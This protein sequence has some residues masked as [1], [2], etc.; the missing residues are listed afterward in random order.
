MKKFLIEFKEFA[1]KGNVVDLSVGVI[2]GGAFQAIIKSFIDNILNPIIG[3]LFKADLS[4]I[5]LKIGSV[6]LGIGAFVSS[7]INF[8][9][10]ALVLFI[11]VYTMNNIR[12]LMKEDKPEEVKKSE[13]V[14][15]L[16]EILKELK[17][18]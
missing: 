5:V 14:I 15:L 16:S 7:F 3:I 6:S 12:G 17:N 10:L 1:L 4:L 2:I 18:K 13:E 8:I 11:M 9:L